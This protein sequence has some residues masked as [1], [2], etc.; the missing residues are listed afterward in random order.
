MRRLIR[1]WSGQAVLRFSLSI[2]VTPISKMIATDSRT[3][4]KQ[5][6]VKYDTAVFETLQNEP[7]SFFVIVDVSRGGWLRVCTQRTGTVMTIWR[8]SNWRAL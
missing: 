4:L 7:A 2:H 1:D 6:A 8:K 3:K 5:A